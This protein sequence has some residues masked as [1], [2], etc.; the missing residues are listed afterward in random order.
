MK[1]WIFTLPLL[2]A[3]NLALAAEVKTAPPDQA[4]SVSAPVKIGG[5]RM[6]KRTVRKFRAV[7]LPRGDLRY[8][9]ERKGNK[10]IIR[11]SET[12]RKR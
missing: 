10:A 5:H 2:C 4:A 6:H 11:C 1:T 3:V 9:L 8:C 12:R 7:K